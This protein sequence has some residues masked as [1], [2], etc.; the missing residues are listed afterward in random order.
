MKAIIKM[1]NNDTIDTIEVVGEDLTIFFSG[2]TSALEVID[3]AASDRVIFSTKQNVLCAYIWNC[4]DL[5]VC[6]KE[7]KDD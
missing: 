1:I 3:R 5:P 2:I 7:D 4:E 6:N